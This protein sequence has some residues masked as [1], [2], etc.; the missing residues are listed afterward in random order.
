MSFG[1]ATQENAVS[2]TFHTL[3]LIAGLEANPN[4]KSRPVDLNVHGGVIIKKNLVVCGNLDVADIINGDLNGNVFTNYITAS[5]ITQGITVTGNLIVDDDYTF[6]ANTIKTNVITS[7]GDDIT[8]KATD[9]IILNTPE[10]I[11]TGNLTPDTSNVYCIGTQNNKWNKVYTH[12]LYAT[13]NIFA[14]LVNM[15]IGGNIVEANIF[16]A[17]KEIQTDKISPKNGTIVSLNAD[18]NLMG[19]DIFASNSIATNYILPTTGNLI[20][21]GN[22]HIKDGSLDLGEGNI[23]NIRQLTGKNGNLLV[24][25]DLTIQNGNID[26]SCGNIINIANIS[27]QTIQPKNGDNILINGNLNLMGNDILATN[28]I[29]TNFISPGTGNLIVCGNLDIK[30][31]SLNLAGGN[32]TNIGQITSQSGNLVINGNIAIQNG[33]L[34]I[35]CGN[36]ANVDTLFIQTINPK[37]GDEITINGNLNVTGNLVGSAITAQPDVFRIEKSGTQILSS[38]NLGANITMTIED[39]NNLGSFGSFLTDTFTISKNGWYHIN[40]SANLGE[41]DNK[42]TLEL[43]INNNPDDCIGQSKFMATGENT[44]LSLDCTLYLQTSDTVK[45]RVKQFTTTTATISDA[46]LAIFGISGTAAPNPFE[47]TLTANIDADCFS[48]LNTDIIQANTITTKT[49]GNLIVAGTLEITDTL[50]VSNIL[51]TSPVTL[52]DGAIIGDNAKL[53]FING[54]AIGDATTTVTQNNAVALGKGITAN[55]PGGFFVTHTSSGAGTTAI[56]NGDQLQLLTSAKRFKENI[57]PLEN[58]GT[59]IDALKPVRFKS[60]LQP[61][62]ESIGFIAEDMEDVFPEFVTHTSSGETLSIM[63]EMIVSALTKEIQSLRHRV[64]QG[65]IQSLHLQQQITNLIQQFQ[66]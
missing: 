35:G 1:G 18:L 45:V 65:E 32:I 39:S 24:Q 6:C 58:I 29:V 56:W 49:G 20:V 54:I 5:D 41:L 9:M 44:L 23:A 61:F 47:G 43:L 36:I 4:R 40:A 53:S 38:G 57:R 21:C 16:C 48:I 62:R 37:T 28:S 46:H 2:K 3:T 33:D 52:D 27:V 63:Y 50:I 60:K 8:I 30:D 26:L 66:L 19:N 12:D 13:G 14:N 51:G 31:G 55:T 59:Q 42:A 11:L 64:A 17:E 34:D 10:I 22:L 25:G 15:V 7:L